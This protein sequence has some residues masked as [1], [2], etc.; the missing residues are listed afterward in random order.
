MHSIIRFGL[1]YGSRLV[2]GFVVSHLVLGANPNNFTVIKIVSVGVTIISSLALIMGIREYKQKRAPAPLSFMAGLV[3]GLGISLIAAHIFALYNWF[4]LVFINPTFTTTYL[5]HSEQKI[6]LSGLAPRVIEQQLTD[7]ANYADLMS[8]NF[9]QFMVMFV[10]VFA[11]G[12][13][14]SLVSA[15]ILRTPRKKLTPYHEKTSIKLG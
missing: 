8:N 1:L 13:L 11:I 14:F 9:T 6:R 15:L 7:L 5:Q 12:F 2:I 4:Y 10:T 3:V